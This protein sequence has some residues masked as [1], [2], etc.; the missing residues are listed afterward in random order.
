MNKE[1]VLVAPF[2]ISMFVMCLLYKVVLYGLGKRP[3]TCCLV[4]IMNAALTACLFFY[5]T[6]AFCISTVNMNHMLYIRI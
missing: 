6:I 2:Y 4:V 3:I 5:S 1:V